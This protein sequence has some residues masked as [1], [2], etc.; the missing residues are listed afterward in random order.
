MGLPYTINGWRAV[1]WHACA[2]GQEELTERLI[3]P[4]KKRRHVC[5]THVANGKWQIG[6]HLN[7]AICRLPFDLSFSIFKQ[8]SECYVETQKS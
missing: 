1:L 7:F 5:A 6:N 2:I 8:R 3:H 4:D